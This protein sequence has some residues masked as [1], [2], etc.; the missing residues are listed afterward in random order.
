MFL[1][2]A[3][4]VMVIFGGSFTKAESLVEGDPLLIITEE[5]IPVDPVPVEPIIPLTPDEGGGPIWE[6]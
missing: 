4:V 5:P 3:F 2:L 6:D 1:L